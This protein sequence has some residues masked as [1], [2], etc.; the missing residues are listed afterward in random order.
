MKVIKHLG[1]IT[2]GMKTEWLR[3]IYAALP[4]FIVFALYAYVRSTPLMSEMKIEKWMTLSLPC[5]LYISFAISQESTIKRKE[6]A[7]FRMLR[8]SKI[9][10]FVYKAVFISL[11]MLFSVITT[12][13]LITDFLTQMAFPVVFVINITLHFGV[14]F[15]SI[16]MSDVE[17]KIS[18]NLK[19]QRKH[20]GFRG[21]ITSY[22]Y[23]SYIASRNRFEI[24][25]GTAIALMIM[26]IVVYY[27]VPYVI[28]LYFVFMILGA[29]L[30]DLA[31]PDEDNHVLNLL[32]KKD[33]PTLARIKKAHY[34]IEAF[35]FEVITIGLFFIVRKGSFNLPSMLLTA[36]IMYIYWLIVSSELIEYIYEHY[37]HIRIYSHA[38]TLVILIFLFPV[39]GLALSVIRSAKRL[40][41]SLNARNQKST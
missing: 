2:R 21:K 35:L 28:A 29:G 37:L 41:R 32:L 5:L 31:K 25:L 12:S 39:V 33:V 22:I 20:F 36:V 26:C 14:I 11:N 18:F 9:D 3:V 27:D 15:I 7:L 10:V 6:K 13:M 17:T 4:P 34:A 23:Y 24:F 30:I 1:I 8:F 38:L 40:W 16:C 19:K